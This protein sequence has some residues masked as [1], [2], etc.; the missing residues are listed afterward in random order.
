VVADV[1]QLVPVSQGQKINKQIPQHLL[2]QCHRQYDL[3]LLANLLLVEQKGKGEQLRQNRKLVQRRS[4][5]GHE[6]K[7]LVPGFPN[8]PI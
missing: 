3:H 4:G 6:W 8:I 2:R 7:R 5:Q 1:S